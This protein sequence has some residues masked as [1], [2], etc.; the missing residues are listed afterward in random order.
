MVEATPTQRA[1]GGAGPQTSEL[2]SEARGDLAGTVAS[3]RMP[4]LVHPQNRIAS[5][6]CHIAVGQL[7]SI[8]PD[9]SAT[10]IPG[11]AKELIQVN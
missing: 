7:N 10:T 2:G 9:P 8:S 1:T 4:T 6:T 11:N 3:Q 5:T